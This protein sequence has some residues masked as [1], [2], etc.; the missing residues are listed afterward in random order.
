PCGVW[1]NAPTVP[2]PTNPK[3]PVNKGAGSEASLPVTLRVRR[4]APKLLFP[5]DSVK[6]L[7]FYCTWY[8]KSA[9]QVFRPARRL[10]CSWLIT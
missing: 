7:F 9:E 4:L 1:G 10:I 3:E 8:L 5:Q 6:R 2:R